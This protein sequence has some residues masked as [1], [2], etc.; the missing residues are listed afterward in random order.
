MMIPVTI[1]KIFNKNKGGLGRIQ[2]KFRIRNFQKAHSIRKENVVKKN[3]KRS[4]INRDQ[5]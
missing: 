3:N 2:R 1:L 4:L 5:I